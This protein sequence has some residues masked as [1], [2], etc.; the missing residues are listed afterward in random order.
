MCLKCSELD[1]AD[2][3][4]HDEHDC[5]WDGEHDWCDSPCEAHGDEAECSGDDARCQWRSDLHGHCEVKLDERV[6]SALDDASSCKANHLCRWF[7]MSKC[8]PQGYIDVVR[9]IVEQG[10]GQLKSQEDCTSSDADPFSQA[11]AAAT[12]TTED[13]ELDSSDGTLARRTGVVFVI[14]LSTTLLGN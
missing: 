10:T 12:S 8:A 4:K 13:D 6:C 2:C 9:C 14:V 3:D 11:F 7:D 5:H 1:K